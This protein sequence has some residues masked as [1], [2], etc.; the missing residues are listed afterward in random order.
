MLTRARLDQVLAYEPTTG[1]FRWKTDRFAGRKHACK[2]ASAG[3]LAGSQTWK[4]YW[5]IRIDGRC[6]M[7]HRLAWLAVY[8][9][10]PVETVDHID[11]D[12]RN[13]QIANLRLASNGQNLWNRK[14]QRNNTSG[15]K[16][17]TF[18]RSRSKWIAQIAVDGRRHH[19][20]RFDSIDDASA[21]YRCAAVKYHGEFANF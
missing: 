4:G 10:W 9:E 18:D 2:I 15:S 17:V 21:A 12:R 13:N 5:C 3:D 20:G 6:Y 16:G 7:S 8:G 14:A 19:L 11:G 1:E